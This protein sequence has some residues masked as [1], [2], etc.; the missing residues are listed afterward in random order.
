MQDEAPWEYDDDM[1]EVRELKKA[2]ITREEFVGIDYVEEKTE[3]E[4]TAEIVSNGLSFI[5]S[6]PADLDPVAQWAFYN[7]AEKEAKSAKDAIA[8][9]AL[10]TVSA[11]HNKFQTTQYGGAQLIEKTTKKPKDTLKFILQQKGQ[12]DMCRKDDI[13]LKKVDELVEAG[14]LDRSEIDN[15]IEIKKT[16]HLQIKK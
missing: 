13:D 11:T 14:I 6:P 9:V 8:K 12:L 5:V 2:K 10:K 1:I 3:S 16:S 15:H 4:K 7:R